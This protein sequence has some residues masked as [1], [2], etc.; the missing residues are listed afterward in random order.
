MQTKYVGGEIYEDFSNDPKCQAIVNEWVSVKH[1]QVITSEEQLVPVPEEVYKNQDVE[2]ILSYMRQ[3]NRGVSAMKTARMMMLGK[4]RAGKTSLA[5]TL[6][7][8]GGKA[9]GAT[10]DE[11]GRGTVGVVLKNWDIPKLSLNISIWDFGKGLIVI[12]H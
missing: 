11:Q 10:K 3:G 9:S 2:G 6:A 8:H 4:V 12:L 7:D 5:N 1:S